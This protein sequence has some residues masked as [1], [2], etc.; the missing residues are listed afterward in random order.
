MAMV[1]LCDATPT[2]RPHLLVTLR[3]DGSALKQLCLS[4][5]AVYINY[6]D[7]L[8]ARVSRTERFL[9]LDRNVDRELESLRTLCGRHQGR[10][11]L[12]DGLDALL[13]YLR[14]RSLVGAD[15]FCRR[16]CYLRQL[17]AVLWVAV[18]PALVP[19]EWPSSRLRTLDE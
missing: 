8:L 16:L 17:E 19:V 2:D 6:R 9:V 10:T 1:D 11:I 13:T 3:T 4:K 5:N 14:A 18:P 12:L 15:V 7:E